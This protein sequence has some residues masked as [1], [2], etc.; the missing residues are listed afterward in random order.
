MQLHQFETCMLEYIGMP[1]ETHIMAKH[2]CLA[3]TATHTESLVQTVS[4]MNY[5]ADSRT[6]LAVAMMPITYIIYMVKCKV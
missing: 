3:T 6:H 4:I 5:S 2:L 1:K